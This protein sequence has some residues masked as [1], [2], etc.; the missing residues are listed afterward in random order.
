[1]F[2]T[3]LS[4][5][6]LLSI[7]IN[8]LTNWYTV[9][10][11]RTSV[12]VHNKNHWLSTQSSTRLLVREWWK[13]DDEEVIVKSADTVKIGE[14][15]LFDALY[16][17]EEE[18]VSGEHSIS[19]LSLK[20]ISEAYQFSL[21]YLGDFVV[22]MGCKPP[23]DVNTNI[24]NILTGEQIYALLQAVTSL[25]PVQSNSEYDSLSLGELAEELN[26]PIDRLVRISEKYEVNLPF[27]IDTILHET[28]AD[29]LRGI[30]QYDAEEEEAGDVDDI[31][32]AE[33]FDDYL[34]R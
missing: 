18:D 6:T 3:F 31:L 19:A 4:L 28:V 14:T 21:A 2:I 32:D 22:Q 13:R 7:V 20:E 9:T 27:G 26:V 30:F 16:N 29:Q 1:M 17:S 25:D 12:I 10:A 11:L 33:E 34:M 8:I 15:S 23:V 24:A 5:F